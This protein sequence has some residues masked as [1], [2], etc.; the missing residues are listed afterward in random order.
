MQRTHQFS[1]FVLL[2]KEP[3]QMQRMLAYESSRPSSLPARVTFRVNATPARS[4]EGGL[5]SQAKRMLTTSKKLRF[6]K[7]ID[8]SEIRLFPENQSL[9]FHQISRNLA[10][11]FIRK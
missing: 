6:S 4:K 11:K 7:K 3:S 8:F 10:R 5:F 9:K 1:A 2:P